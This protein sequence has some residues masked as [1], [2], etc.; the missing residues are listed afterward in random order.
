MRLPHPL[1]A[2]FV[3]NNN[4]SV[5][6][7]T[8]LDIPPDMSSA[9]PHLCRANLLQSREPEFP[10]PRRDSR[11]DEQE[12][13]HDAAGAPV[14]VDHR[15]LCKFESIGASFLG[16]GPC[17][18]V[19]LLHGAEQHRRL[20]D[21]AA[22]LLRERGEKLS[23]KRLLGRALQPVDTDSSPSRRHR[24]RTCCTGRSACTPAAPTSLPT[25]RKRR[26]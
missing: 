10:L 2:Q 4:W 12:R 16:E 25:C 20:A 5:K 3:T 17:A 23:E 21:R 11:E 14:R 19:A 22:P 6:L 7:V 9:L 24:R 13:P 1:S 8:A 15:F 18:N 26:T